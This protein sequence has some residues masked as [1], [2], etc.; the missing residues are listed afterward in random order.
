MTRP[1]FGTNEYWK[2][3]YKRDKDGIA[4]YTLKN[5]ENE[6]KYRAFISDIYEEL[7]DAIRITDLAIQNGRVS[8]LDKIRYDELMMIKN[9]VFICIQRLM[10]LALMGNCPEDWLQDNLPEEKSITDEIINGNL[11]DL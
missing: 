8:P 11:A 7:Y 1:K 6:I 3:I 5:G 2:Y 4:R 10:R 9:R